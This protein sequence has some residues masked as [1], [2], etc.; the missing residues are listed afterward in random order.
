MTVGLSL[1]LLSPCCSAADDQRWARLASGPGAFTH[2][3]LGLAMPLIRDRGN[4]SD[5]FWRTSEALGATILVTEG[6]KHLTRVPRPDNGD[7]DSFPSGHSSASFAIAT[8]EA[9]F[10][11]KEAALWY[12]G[13][14][15][16][17]DSRLVL[18]RHR[19]GDVLAG[20]GLGFLIARA[21]LS[22]RRG[23]VVRPFLREND[24]FN[25]VTGAIKGPSGWSFTP[26]AGDGRAYGLLAVRHF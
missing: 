5:H 11:P 26:V 24:N 1:A 17:A 7:P 16:I 4:G 8:M 6:L 10:H 3:G 21:E 2:I 9:S 25:F 22:S 15:V 12:L 14:A 13:A 18:R 23:W 19:I 20:A